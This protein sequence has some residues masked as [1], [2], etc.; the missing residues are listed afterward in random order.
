METLYARCCGLDVHQKQ[1]VAC[2]L[3]PGSGGIPTNEIRTFGTMTEGLLALLDWLVDAGCTHVAMESTGVLWKPIYNLF[4]GVLEVLVVNAQHIKQVPGRKTDVKDAEW[5]ATLLRHGLLRPSFIPDR[6]QRELRELT[7]YRTSLRQERSAE[8]NRLHK[9]LEGANI[10]LGAVA[11]NIVGLSARQM[12]HALAAG[13]TDAAVLARLAQGRLRDK[14]PQLEQ[15][16]AGTMQRHQRFLLAQQLTH[17]DDLDALIARLDGEIA[18][19]LQPAEEAVAQLDTIPGVG[20]R[21]RAALPER[22]APGRLGGRRAGQQRERRQ[23]QEREDAQGQPLAPGGAG[24]GGPGGGPQ[25]ADGAGRLLPAHRGAA[26]P[27]ARPDRH[28]PPHPGGGLLPAQ[29]WWRVPRAGAGLLRRPGSPG[30]RTPADPPT[31]RARL[32]GHPPANH[33]SGRIARNFRAAE[34][35]SLR[36][37]AARTRQRDGSGERAWLG[38]FHDRFHAR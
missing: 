29:G 12:L 28:R 2:L 23:A 22:G 37:V 31:P 19:R 3:T 32:R 8:V 18:A 9:H 30:P 25:Q 11:S 16:L 35:S 14:I 4:E 34:L 5:I 38:Y 20:R 27:Q 10:K 1:V 17:L 7:R 13:E 21:R 33:R 15:A 6:A 24:R 26:G 36:P